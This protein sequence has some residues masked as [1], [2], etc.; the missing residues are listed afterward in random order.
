MSQG[1][2][3]S[4]VPEASLEQVL[5]QVKRVIVGQDVL[6][7][8]MVVALLARGHLLVEG[9]P[10]LA[11]TLAVKAMADALGVE[12]QRIQFTP[13]LVPADI[14][15]TRIYNQKVGEFQVSLGPVF[16][17]LVLADEINRAPA[18]VQS[19]LLEAMQERQVTIGRETHPL[20]DPF[21][22]MATQNPI[23][24][25]G[26]YPL[27]EA[28]VDRFMLK[29]L[30]DY[31]TV[32][33]EFVIVERMIAGLDTIQGVMGSQ[34]LS[35]LQ[36]E[37]RGIYVDPSLIEYSVRVSGATRD[38]EAVGLKDMAGYVTYG[39]SPR[40]SIYMILAAQG[41]ALLRGRDY[42]LPEDVQALARDVLRHRLVLSYEALGDNVTA[43]D[44]LDEILAAVPAPQG[45]TAERHISHHAPVDDRTWAPPPR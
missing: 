1:G 20:P 27:P 40:A 29:V 7:E 4:E 30:V 14:V 45:G 42:V 31:P 21:L 15:G 23:E 35:A 9:V 8:R 19:A 41:L 38:L 39:A 3:W 18:K 34:Q 22:V 5:Y 28:Q 11:K 37:T 12:F 25:D 43:E 10:G 17:N 2:E 32:T 6:L 16:A 36:R 33:E 26:T 13:D 44:I 24:S